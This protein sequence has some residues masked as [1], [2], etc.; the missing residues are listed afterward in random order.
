MP[1]GGKNSVNNLAVE[2]A[3]QHRE[4]DGQ[5]GDT[6]D[7]SDDCNNQWELAMGRAESHRRAAQ[8][9]RSQMAGTKRPWQPAR[10]SGSAAA[11]PSRA[12]SL[13]GAAGPR[14]GEAQGAEGPPG[15]S[16]ADTEDFQVFTVRN[17]LESPVRRRF[18]VAVMDGDVARFRA[19]V[20]GASDVPADDVVLTVH[21]RLML[22]GESVRDTGAATE[23]DV[24]ATRKVRGGSPS[25][26]VDPEMPVDDGIVSSQTPCRRNGCSITD[27]CGS[28]GQE[29]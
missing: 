15:A 27:A 8:G 4:R 23:T 11:A 17:F 19:Q 13:R 26:V 25:A 10:L 18:I 22:N 21:S 16:S 29:G 7:E 20:G 2:E 12:P 5:P 6:E 28:G 14:A 9:P 1:A 24:I 3:I